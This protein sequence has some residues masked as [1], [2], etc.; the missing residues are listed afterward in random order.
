VLVT[1]VTAGTL[2][3]SQ[4]Q[5]RYDFLVSGIVPLLNRFSVGTTSIAIGLILITLRRVLR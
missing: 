1:A 2:H 5:Y 3:S 4:S